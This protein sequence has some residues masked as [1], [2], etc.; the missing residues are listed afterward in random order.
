M[1]ILGV[2]VTVSCRCNLKPISFMAT[3]FMK[4]ALLCVVTI[5]ALVR[6][7]AMFSALKTSTDLTPSTQAVLN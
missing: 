5:H 7:E 6:D 1:S 2:S 4:C 3:A